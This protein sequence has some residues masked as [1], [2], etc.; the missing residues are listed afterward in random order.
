MVANNGFVN[1]TIPP[2]VPDGFYLMRHEIIALH[3]A[4]NYP[5]AQFYVRILSHSFLRPEKGIIS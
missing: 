3:S 4:Y 2:C 1:V 5:G